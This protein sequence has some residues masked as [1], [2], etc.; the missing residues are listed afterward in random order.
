MSNDI[1]NSIL[2]K[3]QRRTARGNY[4]R[5]LARRFGFIDLMSTKEGEDKV[6]LSKIYVPI[7]LGRDDVDE[8]DIEDKEDEQKLGDDARD[9]IVEHD[10][11]AVSHVNQV[12]P[13]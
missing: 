5:W 11:V 9:V 4:T 10:F 7:H 2:G 13:V 1:D 8:N 3:N 6:A 12:N